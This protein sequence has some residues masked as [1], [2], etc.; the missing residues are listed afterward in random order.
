MSSKPNEVLEGYQSTLDMLQIHVV[1]NNPDDIDRAREQRP[2]LILVEVLRETM[3]GLETIRRFKAAV[4]TKAV[5][6][7]AIAPKAVPGDRDLWLEKG[8]DG[9]LAKPFSLAAT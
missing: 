9:Y 2:D 8:C 7:L 1:T 5:P 4:Q 6:I 3:G